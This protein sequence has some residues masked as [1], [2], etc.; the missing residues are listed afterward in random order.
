MS[1]V[2]GTEAAPQCVNTYGPES[3]L[4]DGLAEWAAVLRSRGSGKVLSRLGPFCW[5]H[6]EYE[7]RW[8]EAMGMA[9]L[10]EVEPYVPTE[11]TTQ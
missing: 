6:A 11:P 4:H 2:I 3:G 1:E 8:R 7:R 10:A 5:V 9:A